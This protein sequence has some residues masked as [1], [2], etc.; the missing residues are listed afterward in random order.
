MWLISK[1]KKR[2]PHGF[3]FDVLTTFFCLQRFVIEDAQQG[4]I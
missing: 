1:G 2:S 4:R 3:L